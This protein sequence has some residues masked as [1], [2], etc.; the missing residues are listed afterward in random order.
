MDATT[1]Q[2][3][4]TIVGRIERLPYS[5]WHTF[6]RIVLGACTFFDA[7]DVIVIA[8][9][10][11]VLAP[12]WHLSP[13]EIGLLFS[14]GFAGQLIG[15]ALFGWLGERYGRIATLNVAIVFISLFGLACALAWSYWPLVGFRFLQGL[16]IGGE[17]PLAAT[18]VSEI[19]KAKARGRFVLVYQLLYPIGLMSASLISLVVVRNFGWQWMFAIGALPAFMMI[20]I[21]RAVPESPRWLARKGRLGEADRVLTA[22][23]ADVAAGTI[24]PPVAPAAPARVGTS[25]GAPGKTAPGKTAP[26]E[27]APGQL[28][29]LFRGPYGRRTLCLWL[30]WFCASSAGYGLL[31]WLPTLFAKFYHLSVQQS[32]NYSAVGN[33]AALATGILAAVLID[34]VGRK[35]L[36]AVSF[37]FTG[38]PLL[39]LAALT[40]ASAVTVMVLA[41]LAT[42]SISAAQLSVWAYTPENYPTRIRAFGVSAASA[43][44]R[45]ASMIAPS[46]VGYLL[47][48]ASINA[49]FLLFGVIA[50]AGVAAILWF[51]QETSGRTLEEI[52][53]DGAKAA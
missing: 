50:M 27:T 53:P 24:L 46:V 10:M 42:A 9:V 19:A 4:E 38:L 6:V 3:Y 41:A 45:A 12:L 30:M 22:I 25:A 5:R 33:V 34:R 52:S 26:G 1:T 49:V 14:S 44:A 47:A 40:E 31:I 36:F 23:E 18:Y 37:F 2:T 39:A 7:Y 15:A 35:T 32:L 11:P 43:V 13:S 48:V 21:F 28:A 16:G 8:F 29:D 17:P 51:G 20:A